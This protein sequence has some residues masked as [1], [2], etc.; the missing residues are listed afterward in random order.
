MIRL[1]TAKQL[2]SLHPNSNCLPKHRLVGGFCEPVITPPNSVTKLTVPPVWT[3]VFH[4]RYRTFTSLVHSLVAV[5]LSL[6]NDTQN[7]FIFDPV[8]PLFPFD[9]GHGSEQTRRP[10]LQKGPRSIVF[11]DLIVS[12]SNCC[13]NVSGQIIVVWPQVRFSTRITVDG[14]VPHETNPIASLFTFICVVWRWN[15]DWSPVIRVLLIVIVKSID[16]GAR[17]EMTTAYLCQ[18]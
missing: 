13:N 14:R 8:T 17:K 1:Q 9:S 7:G 3:L 11:P 16:T 6:I 18:Y 4:S 10:I 5:Q 12:A 15:N 2:I